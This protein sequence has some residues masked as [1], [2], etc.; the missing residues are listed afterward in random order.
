MTDD[1]INLITVVII[2]ATTATLIPAKALWTIAKLA[3]LWRK[4]AI[5]N[6]IIIDGKITP[7]VATSPPILRY[8][9]FK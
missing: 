3:K 2:R 4:D 7:S 5:I 8:V 9:H 1:F 6:I